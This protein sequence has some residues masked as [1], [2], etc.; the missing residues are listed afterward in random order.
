ME[1]GSISA[2]SG[3]Y[4]SNGKQRESGPGRADFQ[5]MTPYQTGFLTK[6][7]TL[8]VPDHVAGRLLK[9]AEG[10]SD[11]NL[12]KAQQVF[13]EW[14]T[15]KKHVVRRGEILTGIARKEGVTPEE[16]MEANNL[17]SITAIKPG[18]VLKM[19]NGLGKP[20]SQKKAEYKTDLDS[21][22]WGDLG[23]KVHKGRYFPFLFPSQ[24]WLT[25]PQ[26]ATYGSVSKL[27]GI[28]QETLTTLNRGKELQAGGVMRLR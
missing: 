2:R 23:Y 14:L 4:M 27:F 10:G 1:T 28:P 20:K 25:V 9:L 24:R 21:P 18:Q 16:I 6:C 8:G 17:P 3:H 22:V 7:A 13:Q 11:P 19:P 12:Q 26:G 15:T 5:D